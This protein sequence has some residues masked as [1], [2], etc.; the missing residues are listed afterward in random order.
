MDFGRRVDKVFGGLSHFLHLRGAKH[1]TV[2]DL[3]RY[4]D[5][6]AAELFPAPRLIRDMRVDYGLLHKALRTSTLSWTSGHDVW[7]PKYRARHEGEYRRNLKAW[8]RWVRPDGP[9]RDRCLVYVHGWLEPGSWVEE[10][11]LFVKWTRE[12]DA[13]MVHISLPF[14]GRRTPRHALFSGEFFWTADLVR[15]V[16][17]VRQAIHDTRA[18]ITWLR[19]QGYTKIGATG[20][21]LGGALA[22][23]L[24]CLDP[25]PDYVIPIVAHLELERAVE[26]ASIL[27]RM[28]R[29]LQK[30]GVDR[31]QRRTLFRRLG[32]ARYTPRLAADRQLWIEAR[33]DDWI[34]ADLVEVQ[35][36]RWGGPAIHW[37]PGGHMTFPLHVGDFTRRIER[38]L[39]SQDDGE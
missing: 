37:I 3:E 1:N 9:T 12:L 8:A 25:P 33:D 5:K 34:R 15:S 11:T 21:S 30:W 7:C 32:L 14:H 31:E 38:F 39:E 36:E 35:A 10:A 27:W 28:K 6:P 22:M 2:G 16:E 18:L 24:A 4:L 13:D 26:E 23:L 20:I 17:A 29:D 19:S